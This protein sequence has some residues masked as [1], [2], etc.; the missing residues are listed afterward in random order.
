MTRLYLDLDGVF[1]DFDRH[2]ADLFGDYHPAIPDDEL[3]G[4]IH[5]MP[6]FFRDMPVCPS[7]QSFYWEVDAVW[8]LA[9]VAVLT[10]C[11][12]SAY[13]HVA[14]QKRAWVREHLSPSLTV[15]PVAGGSS[16][17]LFMHAPGDILIDDFARN[18]TA[19][20]KAGG[21]AILHTGD[22]E[23]TGTALKAMLEAT[24]CSA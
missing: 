21:R 8:P 5:S 7:A 2:Y 16:K 14:G 10:A 3:W 18:T 13:A 22:F 15:L 4:K 23:A 17:P 24:P 19:W 20:E 12:K 1:A 9:S 6:T 11:P